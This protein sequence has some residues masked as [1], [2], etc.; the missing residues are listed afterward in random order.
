[1]GISLIDYKFSSQIGEKGIDLNIAVWEITDF[2]QISKNYSLQPFR[3]KVKN[4]VLS[5]Y[6]LKNLKEDPTIAKYRNFYWKYLS[7][8][9]TKI[10]PASEALIRRILGEKVIPD[11]HPLVDCYNWASIQTLIPMG[12][13]DLDAIKGPF[14]I[15]FAADGESF[16]PVGK[17]Q[18]NQL[19]ANALVNADD[20]RKI[21]CQYPYRDA[22]FSRITNETQNLI[23]VAYGC[24]GISK[25]ELFHSL[26]IT[27][28]N[29]DW[30]VRYGYIE[31]TGG[32]FQYF[33]SNSA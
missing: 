12:A 26:S 9:P 22:H 1:M 19:H 7:I 30:L 6:T 23:L 4:D 31:Y 20:D 2:K 10:R 15:R 32:N 8:D 25:K 28:N 29:L 17:T 5:N 27:E 33:T 24:P 14:H 16:I 3:S 11:I 13:Y 21:M 18:P